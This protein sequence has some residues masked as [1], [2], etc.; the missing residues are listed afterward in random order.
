MLPI[1]PD[2]HNYSGFLAFFTIWMLSVSLLM[3]YKLLFLYSSL[4]QNR[5]KLN[6]QILL[7]FRPQPQQR[8]LDKNNIQNP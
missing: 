6:Y 2:H 8:F 7:L 1:L 3:N 5:K 4:S